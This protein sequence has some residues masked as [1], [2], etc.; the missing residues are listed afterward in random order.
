[1]Y[2]LIIAREIREGNIEQTIAVKNRLEWTVV[3]P[4]QI[5]TPTNEVYFCQTCERHNKEFF[6]DVKTW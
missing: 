6:D 5:S 3:G 4:N 1:M 2:A